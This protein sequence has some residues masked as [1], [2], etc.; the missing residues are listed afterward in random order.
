MPQIILVLML[1]LV[2]LAP[3]VESSHLESLLLVRL[4]HCVLSPHRRK[5]W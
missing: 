1:S 3:T 2:V 4:R 5:S